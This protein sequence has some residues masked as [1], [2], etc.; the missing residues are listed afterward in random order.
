MVLIV[1]DD[2]LKPDGI[3]TKEFG[4][5]SHSIDPLSTGWLVFL[6]TRVATPQFFDF[7]LKTVLI[8][9]IIK[10]R[11]TLNL[12]N[13][14]SLFSIDGEFNCLTTWMK[15]D[16]VKQFD[17][18]DILVAKHSASYS[19]RGN[20]LDAGNV[21][22]AT[23]STLKHL[24]AEEVQDLT[25]DLRRNLDTYFTQECAHLKS[26]VRDLTVDAICRIVVS[27]Q[28]AMTPDTVRHG[29]AKTGQYLHNGFDFDTK[30]RNCTFKLTDSQVR[31]MREEFPGL[32]NTMK[33]QGYVTE[34]Q[35]DHCNIPSIVE[36][37]RKRKPK[38]ERVPNQQ[39]AMLVNIP[40][41]LARFANPPVKLAP[42]KRAALRALE[43]AEKQAAKQAAASKRVE[44]ALLALQPNPGPV[45]SRER[46]TK[47]KQ[48]TKT[49]DKEN[50]VPE[51]APKRTKTRTIRTPLRL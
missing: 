4:G 44:A 50:R 12:D 21:F 38:D 36:T 15:P 17:D 19:A 32:T 48:P 40:A 22:K 46:L 13:V 20:A 6:K 24:Y 35:L 16:S 3:R 45:T 7:Y 33:K 37:G 27:S 23:K 2:S 49:S 10:V 11:S 5:L 29:F 28:R 9:H 39:R 34:Q 25:P 47:R 42:Q 51:P 43:K 1:A 8:P 41:N 30:I 31:T 18:A 14:P 26:S